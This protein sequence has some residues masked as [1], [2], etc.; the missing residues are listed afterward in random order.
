M[1]LNS[2]TCFDLTAIFRDSISYNN[3]QVVICVVRLLFVL[4]Y[5]LLCVNVYCHLVTSQLQLINI[6]YIVFIHQHLAR[7]LKGK[8][9]ESIRKAHGSC[10][11]RN[12]Y[13][14]HPETFQRVL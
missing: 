4:L 11:G 3:T 14:H 5:I 8:T 7:L 12:N 9:S 10:L 1:Y 6:S 13:Y 2:A